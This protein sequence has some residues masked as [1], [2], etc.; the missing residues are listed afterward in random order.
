MIS[1]LFICTFLFGNSLPQDLPKKQK[2]CNANRT[3]AV[4]TLHVVLFL[5]YFKKADYRPCAF[6]TKITAGKA[7]VIFLIVYPYTLTR[8]KEI[9]PH[10]LCPGDFAG[11]DLISVSYDPEKVSVFG[12]HF[13]DVQLLSR[14]RLSAVVDLQF[15]RIVGLEMF[16]IIGVQHKTH[17]FD[18]VRVIAVIEARGA[19]H[20]RVHRLGP[21]LRKSRELRTFLHRRMRHVRR[22]SYRLGFPDPSAFKIDRRKFGSGMKEFLSFFALHDR[23]KDQFHRRKLR[24]KTPYGKRLSPYRPA[25]KQ[26][27]VLGNEPHRLILFHRHDPID[28]EIAHQLRNGILHD[29]IRRQ[30]RKLQFT[31][32]HASRDIGILLINHA[33][34]L[35]SLLAVSEGSKEVSLPFSHSLLHPS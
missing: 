28:A 19:D 14:E 8:P 27:T 29:L 31:V 7:L 23:I 25:V 10:S 20:D 21:R 2:T 6:C 9:L 30:D 35:I 17:I 22:K 24:Y 5:F 18:I 33:S 26:E 16:D 32:T 12:R 11:R 3:Y 34:F 4:S 13:L 1:A 15:H